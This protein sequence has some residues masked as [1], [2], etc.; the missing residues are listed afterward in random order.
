MSCYLWFSMISQVVNFSYFSYIYIS[1]LYFIPSFLISFYFISL[2]FQVEKK[3]SV[4]RKREEGLLIVENMFLGVI[5]QI[6]CRV[7]QA[8]DMIYRV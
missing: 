3:K 7:N 6:I 2:I 8:C 5:L 1:S 4:S